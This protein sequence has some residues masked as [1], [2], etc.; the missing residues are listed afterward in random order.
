MGI[1]I[2]QR[3][4]TKKGRTVRT[5][6]SPWDTNPGCQGPISVSKVTICPAMKT[7]GGALSGP[8]VAD[9]QFRQSQTAARRLDIFRM[10][11]EARRC[12][13]RKP[14]RGRETKLR[15][16]YIESGNPSPGSKLH[17]PF[18]KMNFIPN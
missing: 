9:K 2:E 16:R 6:Q 15:T 7:L 8:H 5:E 3:R 4:G 13:L 10:R 1:Q 18:Q 17:L 12:Y 14:Q 11:A